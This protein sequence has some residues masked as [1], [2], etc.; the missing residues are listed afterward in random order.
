MGHALGLVAVERYNGKPGFFPV[1][2]FASS[3]I[4]CWMCLRPMSS[5][6]VEVR[7][8]LYLDSPHLYYAVSC[9][10]VGLHQILLVTE[11]RS[12]VGLQPQPNDDFR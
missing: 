4:I 3:S 6:A 7:L 8:S 1:R 12:D 10:I 2:Y 5:I 11:Y 9:R